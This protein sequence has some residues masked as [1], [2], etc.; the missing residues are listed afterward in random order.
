M[1]EVNR[2]KAGFSVLAQRGCGWPEHGNE[3]IVVQEDLFN[4]A[5]N[6]FHRL[7]PNSRLF[8]LK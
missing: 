6:I 1:K 5:E 4:V 8:I 3:L 7:L 2:E